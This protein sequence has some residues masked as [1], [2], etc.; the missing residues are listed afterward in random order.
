MGA[1]R[2][3]GVECGTEDGFQRGTQTG[4]GP[5]YPPRTLFTDTDRCHERDSRKYT[6]PVD[7]V[8]TRPTRSP[9]RITTPL[10]SPPSLGARS[11]PESPSPSRPESPSS[12]T[13]PPVPGPTRG[14]Q[15]GNLPRGVD[16]D[17]PVVH[18]SDKLPST[19]KSEG[20]V[21]PSPSFV[22]GTLLNGQEESGGPRVSYGVSFDTGTQ[23]G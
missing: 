1:E 11:V 14:P 20:L 21:S 2:G 3:Q 19:T 12:P 9:T 18:T 10:P 7:R 17:G 23:A 15:E 8:P 13:R 22:D 5:R 4:L 16:C 6:W